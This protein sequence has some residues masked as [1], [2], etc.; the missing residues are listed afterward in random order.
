[1]AAV[2][3]IHYFGCTGVIVAAGIVAAVVESMLLGFVKSGAVGQRGLV[4]RRFLLG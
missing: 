2:V 4:M 3:G 1:M